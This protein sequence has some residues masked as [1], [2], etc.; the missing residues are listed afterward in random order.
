MT[1]PAWGATPEAQLVM[2]SAM[3]NEALVQCLRLSHVGLAK[4]F[5]WA[6]FDRELV[7]FDHSGLPVTFEPVD[8]VLSIG[9]LSTNQA[10]ETTGSINFAHNAELYRVAREVHAIGGDADPFV[11][12]SFWYLETDLSQPAF[13]TP[14]IWRSR[15]IKTDR[16]TMTIDLAGK[17]FAK[18]D[19]G[20]R[21]NYQDWP[22]LIGWDFIQ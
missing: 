12:E 7:T 1:S 10:L 8:F 20:L 16:T 5:L 22:T 13:L 9:R 18:R 17:T 15:R 14:W 21:Y 6:N 3:P 19:A 2:S 4:P 11:V